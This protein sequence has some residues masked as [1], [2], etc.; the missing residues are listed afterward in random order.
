MAERREKIGV[1]ILIIIMFIAGFVVSR[2]DFQK[3]GL[4]EGF[5]VYGDTRTNT[6]VH[7]QI[8]DEMMDYN[9]EFVINTGDLVADGRNW[10]QWETFES[11]IKPIRDAGIEYYPVIGNHEQW[12]SGG[13]SNY[14]RIFNFTGYYSFERNGINFVV[15]NLYE[16]YKPNSTQYEWF[17]DEINDEKP[18]IVA[19]HEPHFKANHEGNEGVREYLIPLIESYGVDAVFYGHTHIFGLRQENGIYYIVTGG[20]GAPLYSP[21]DTNL[22]V[23]FKE[24]HFI[25]L[26]KNGD[27]LEADVV[28]INGSILYEFSIPLSLKGKHFSELTGI[29]ALIT[30]K[31]SEIELLQTT[32]IQPYRNLI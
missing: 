23:S 19:M 18:T 20:G 3:E 16:D 17:K 25:Y 32:R 26:E 21:N 27:M 12:N 2:L 11:I 24:H 10:T 14:I 31:E 6:D 22:N 7:H 4:K 15:V 30:F 9:L 29:K 28:S 13:K 8:V 5:V 1:L